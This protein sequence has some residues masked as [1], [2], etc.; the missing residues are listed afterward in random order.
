METNKVKIERP[1]EI[2]A[3]IDKETFTLIME[4][5]QEKFTTLSNPLQKKI[6]DYLANNIQYLFISDIRLIC[7]A[8]TIPITLFYLTPENY[9]AAREFKRV[10]EVITC[11]HCDSS[12]FQLY[13]NK[14]THKITLECYDCEYEQALPEEVE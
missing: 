13:L 7:T 12:K 10:M 1:K 4:D 11:S 6:A 8:Y 2:N 14:E 9:K 3:E 5:Y